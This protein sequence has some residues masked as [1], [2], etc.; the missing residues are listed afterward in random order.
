[1]VTRDEVMYAFRLLLG[2]EPESAA[3]VDQF[4]HVPN[5]IQL[6]ELF[7]ASHEF[8][9]KSNF[10]PDGDALTNFMNSAPNS[11]D[12]EI[13][14]SH[15]DQLINHVHESWESL[16][17]KRPHWSVLTNPIF[18]PDSIEANAASFYDSGE[19]SVTILEKAAARAGKELSSNSTC[20]ELGCGVGRVTSY[21]ARRFARVV[22]ADISE[23]HLK[24]AGMHLHSKGVGNVILMQLKSLDVLEQLDP[25]DIFYSIIVLQHNPPP[26]IYRMLQLIFQKVKIGGYVYFQL[27]VSY[28]GY[29]FSIEEYVAAIQKGEGTM[30]MHVLP[31]KYLFRLLDEYGFRLLDFQRDNWTGRPFH[32]VT[33]FAERIRE[34]SGG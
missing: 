6:R 19:S 23:P 8:C 5:W 2:R 28:P 13:S 34:G 16:G 20:F 14:A 29:R 11:V 15:F 10:E 9:V 17:R 3:I 12:V 27:P 33:A 31:Q 4:L 30:E 18:L 1:M 7:V 24:L 22:A 26:L 21:L 25:F 32:S